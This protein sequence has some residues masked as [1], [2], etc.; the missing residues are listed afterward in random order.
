M[1]N[2]FT[3]EEL[4]ELRTSDQEIDRN[5]ILTDEE[6]ARSRQLDL[7]ARH[8]KLDNRAKAKTKSAKK[9]HEAHKQEI[10]A[11]KAAWYTANRD[12]LVAKQREYRQDNKE[13][14]KNGKADYFRRNADVI[15]AKSKT[16]YQEHKAE[17]SERR[18]SYYKAHKE[19]IDEQHKA[20]YQRT[21]ER[22]AERNKAYYQAHREEIK[23]KQR[24]RYH[25]KKKAA[26]DVQDREQLKEVELGKSST[27]IVQHDWSNVN[28][29]HIYRPR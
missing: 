11:K 15:K 22:A 27:P 26:P 23:A 10:N 28:D 19:R 20:Y 14:V 6:L 1:A 5:F 2:L 17:I 9:Y 7:Q 16:Y 21:K 29:G 13:K 24:A 25:A 12:R 8:E 4:E 3:K 18:A